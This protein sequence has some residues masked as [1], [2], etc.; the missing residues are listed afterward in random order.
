MAD[1]TLPEIYAI[2]GIGATRRAALCGARWCDFKS[3]DWQE[4][5]ERC[6]D[7]DD[8]R[9]WEEIR[10]QELIKAYHSLAGFASQ[11]AAG[12]IEELTEE[13]W[14]AYLDLREQAS[15]EYIPNE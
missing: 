4:Y 5:F 12:S 7:A 15:K 11:A 6:R 14:D 2:M 8:W 1:Y 9:E 10:L 3:H 13:Q